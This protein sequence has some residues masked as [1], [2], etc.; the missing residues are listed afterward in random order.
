M[1]FC[2]KPLASIEIQYKNGERK[3]Y[4]ADEL[5]SVVPQINEW[6]FRSSNPNLLSNTK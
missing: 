1:L 3:K 2:G 5:A 4:E 6:R